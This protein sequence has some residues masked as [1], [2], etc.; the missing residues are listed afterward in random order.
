MTKPPSYIKSMDHLHLHIISSDLVS[1]RLHN[2]K[3]YNSFHPSLGFFIHLDEVLAWFD[4][5]EKDFRQV[6]LGH[7]FRCAELGMTG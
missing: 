5:P 3:H 7:S 1:N 2:K 6:C 4:L